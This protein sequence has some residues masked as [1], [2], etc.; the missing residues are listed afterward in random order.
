VASP[1]D[2][3]K[4][5]LTHECAM[6]GIF[7]PQRSQRCNYNSV[8]FPLPGIITFTAAA[9]RASWHSP[10]PCARL[11]HPPSHIF[12]Y[13]ISV[14]TPPTSQ[15]PPSSPLR[16]TSRGTSP[17]PLPANSKPSTPRSEGQLAAFTQKGSSPVALSP[18]PMQ[19]FAGDNGVSAPRT[20]E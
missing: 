1:L 14:H 4:S 3:K 16:P 18:R 9:T 15:A 10:P 5:K 19:G 17:A 13:R 6:S 8:D 12:Q 7:L 11:D 20:D 2:L